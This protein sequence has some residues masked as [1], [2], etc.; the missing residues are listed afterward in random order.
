MKNLLLVGI[1]FFVSLC[2]YSQL[3]NKHWL[4]PLHANQ[5]Q[6]SNLINGH[7][8][9][10]STPEPTPFEVTITDGGGTI[11]GSPITIS[12]NNPARVLIGNQQPSVMFLNKSDVGSVVSNKGLIIEGLYDFYVSFR[13]R[14]SN[15]AEFL[16]SKG[17]SGLGKTFRL[18]SLPQTSFGA[19]RNF[20]SSFMATEDNTTV[21]LSDYDPNIQFIIGNTTI[22]TPNQSFTLNRGQSVVVSG[23]TNSNANLTGFVG[24]LLTSD[25]PIVVNT[26]NLAGGMGTPTDG[27]DFNLDQIVPLE[28]VGTEYIIMKGNGSSVSELPL[29]IAHEDNTQI[30]VNGSASPIATLNAG[31]FFLIPTS[32]FQG[33]GINKNMYINSVDKPFFL[34]QIIGGS[35]SDATSGFFFIPPINCFWQKSVDLIPDIEKIIT[36]D[37]FSGNVIIATEVGSEVKINGIITNTPPE[38]VTG[39]PNWVTYKIINL[40]GN[41]KVESSGA[42]AVGVFG[43]SGSAGYGGYFSGFGSLPKDSEITVCSNSEINLFE[44]I[45]GNPDPNGTWT[46]PTGGTPLNG[47]LFDSEINLPGD[48][49]YTFSKTCDG[50]TRI[51]PIK[52]TVLPIQIGP[53]AGNDDSVSFCETDSIIDLTTFLGTN[54]TTEGNWTYNNNAIADGNIDPSNNESGDYKYTIPSNGI[55]DE[56]SATLSVTINASPT[57]VNTITD[58]ETCDDA[59]DGDTSGE[60]LFILTDKDEQITNSEANLSVNYY[61]LLTDAENNNTNNITSIRAFTGKTIF[62]RLYNTI[63]N[64][65]TISSFNLVVNP[66]PTVN[67]NVTLKQCDDNNDAITSFNLTEANTLI[68][69]NSDVTFTYHNSQFGAENKSDYVTDEINHVAPNGST[70]WVRI[71]NNTTG[72][73]RVTNINLVVSTANIMGN[74]PL[75][76]HKCDYYI[77]VNNTDTDGIDVFD[78]TEIVT[79]INNN[80]AFPIGQTFTYSYYA[81]QQDALAELNPIQNPNTYTNVT[82][83][84]QDIWVRI[85]SDLNNECYGL[86]NYIRLIVDPLPNTELGDD[87]ILCLDPFTGTGQQLLDATPVTA[88]NYSYQWSSNIT[89]LDL[90]GET[91]ATYLITQAGT[92]SVLVKNTI[93]ECEFIDSITATASSE[94]MTFTAEVTTPAFSGNNVTIFGSSEGGYGQYEYSLDGVNWQENN[95]F[96]NLPSDTY[97]VYVR[98]LGGCG[99][100]SV[101]NLFAITYPYY[102]TPNG[103]GYNDTWKINHLDDSYNA[104]IFIYDRYGKLLKQISPNGNGWNGTYNGQL[105]PASDYWFRIEYT[106][107]GQRKEFKSHFSLKR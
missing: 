8:I 95:T 92:Y 52:I 6:D 4:P 61:E 101:T 54:I 25:K 62:F 45:P 77:D 75:E 20:V 87:F 98:D 7:Y 19:I 94:P 74:F 99:M 69:T 93:S 47:N 29:V 104:Q 64:C 105:L 81:T 14:A 31:D 82:P 86:S 46:I 34:Y 38:L 11:I 76:L 35:S 51:F 15:H 56:V 42:L 32:Y 63:T 67:S 49:I 57:L 83:H 96:T 48:Y 17:R 70:V 39:N 78:L 3:S 79:Y 72:C 53:N 22:S 5:D 40:T 65:F 103:D 84:S 10:L 2:S 12:Q 85:D 100:L 28:Q 88:G 89:S 37:S 16:S 71:E 68:S 18:G 23:Y 66:L 55:C 80:N 27:Q 13:V 59:I 33:T 36:S 41:V 50:V 24:A 26:G 73:Y 106:E 30:F 43:A 58:L 102:F 9:Y 60:T 107:K 90:S 44:S 91:N 21:N 1:L 97:T